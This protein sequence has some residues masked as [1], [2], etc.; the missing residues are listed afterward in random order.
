ML[1]KS[2][3]IRLLRVC[4][5]ALVSLMRR[6]HTAQ[7]S[8]ALWPCIIPNAAAVIGAVM[9]LL[10]KCSFLGLNQNG[11]DCF[12]AGTGWWAGL[13]RHQPPPPFLRRA[14]VTHTHTVLFTVVLDEPQKAVLSVFTF[15]CLIHQSIERKITNYFDNQL[16]I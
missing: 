2:G 16:N 13:G 3:S 4:V 15:D 14:N 7:H 1:G 9:W 11:Q 12:L 6:L 8:T 10:S 5:C